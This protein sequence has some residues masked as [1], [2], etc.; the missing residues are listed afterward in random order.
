MLAGLGRGVVSP[1]VE[2]PLC[3]DADDKY[4]SVRTGVPKT[5]TRETKNKP[6]WTSDVESSE[7]SAPPRPGCM[8]ACGCAKRNLLLWFTLCE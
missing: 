5:S 4:L 1:L 8:H 2:R 6:E 3:V 7:S